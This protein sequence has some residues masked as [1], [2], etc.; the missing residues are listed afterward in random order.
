MLILKKSKFLRIACPRC[1]S[2]QIVFGKASIIIKC[3]HCN[4]RLIDTTGGKAK[5]KAKV[6]QIL[7]K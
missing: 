5:I 1:A 6:R 2:E 3:P 7:W 4:K